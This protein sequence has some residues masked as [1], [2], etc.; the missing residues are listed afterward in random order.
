MSARTAAQNAAWRKIRPHV[1]GAPEHFTPGKYRCP[2][3][4]DKG[5]SLKVDYR[6]NEVRLSCFSHN[7]ET[8]QVL[9]RL[10]LRRADL[11]D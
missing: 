9:D 3:H 7:C 11:S 8:Q 2:A 5:K 6:D 1:Q 4:D 10:G